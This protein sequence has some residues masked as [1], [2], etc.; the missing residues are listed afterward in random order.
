ME[1]ALHDG[2]T[3]QMLPVILRSSPY[4]GTCYRVVSK[5][6]QVHPVHYGNSKAECR[7]NVRCHP[8]LLA[9]E[10]SG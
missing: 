10:G 6:E 5:S 7:A 9:D 2:E 1:K 8:E 4:G 3:L